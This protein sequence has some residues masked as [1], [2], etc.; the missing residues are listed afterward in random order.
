MKTFGKNWLRSQITPEILEKNG[1]DFAPLNKALEKE[2][3]LYFYI[4]DS[5][6]FDIR[7]RKV[8]DN[9]AY[10][11]S[12]AISQIQYLSLLQSKIGVI[13]KAIHDQGSENVCWAYAISSMLRL[14]SDPLSK[15][16]T[17]KTLWKFSRTRITIK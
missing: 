2:G 6:G 16:T 9:E 1:V 5:F 4:L 7:S 8:N 10:K 14:R 11:L 12:T 3:G 17:S 15:N 13:S